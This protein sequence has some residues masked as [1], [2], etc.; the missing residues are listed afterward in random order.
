MEYISKKDIN[1]N[2][3][4]RLSEKTFES[5]IYVSDSKVYKMYKKLK[6]YRRMVYLCQKEPKA[7]LLS[8]SSSSQIVKS[9]AIILGKRVIEGIR[10]DYIENSRTLYEFSRVYNDLAKYL[11]VGNNASKGLKEIHKNPLDI[12]VSDLNFFNILF[13]E[14]LNT[15]YV[16]SDSYEVSGYPATSDSKQFIQYCDERGLRENTSQKSDRFLF[17]FE[18]LSNIFGTN[19]Q[20][21]PT[22]RYDKL[23][24]QVASLKNMRVYFK[25]IKKSEKIPNVP[26]VCDLIDKSDFSK[27]IEYR[28]P[29][30]NCKTT[31]A[32]KELTR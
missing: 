10:M 28:L 5:T 20:S 15:Y 7:L 6:F 27:Q 14:E 22:Y 8:K 30:I 25:K 9:D 23:A 2:E 17:M 4:I 16:D 24:E 18:F 26:H 19:I 1:L 29:I 13:D 11:I 3:A 12:V 32:L 21:V 31:P